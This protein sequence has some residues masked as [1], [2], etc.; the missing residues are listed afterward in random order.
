MRVLVTGGA[1]FIGC[2]VVGLLASRGHQVSVFDD[3][4]AGSRENVPSSACLL[5][6]DILDPSALERALAAMRPDVVVHL[7]AQVNVRVSLR[8]PALDARV[9]VEGSLRV[10]GAGIRHGVRRFLFASS[11]GAVYGTQDY[12][13]ADEE[14]P[15]R[16]ES[17]YGL[18]KLTVERYLEMLASLHRFEAVS[19]R[20][21][22]VYGPRQDPRGEAGVIAIFT[23]RLI[24]GET[25]V[26][27]GDGLQTRDYVYVGDVAEAFAAAMEGP[28]GTY[29]VGTGVETSVRD[30]LAMIA[31]AVGRDGS[32]RFDKAIP[33]ELRRSCLQIEKARQELGWF[34]KVTLSEGILRTVQHFMANPR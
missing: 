6:G 24:D 29:N 25:P 26:I 12:Y 20:L 30:I 10:I 22:N 18:A 34:P 27:F 28:P 7:A 2:H 32:P 21:S 9:N 3:L 8:D 17:P 33:G 19:L 16:P 11:G 14:H 23:Q 31:R 1:G 15:A 5:T 4:S 13:P